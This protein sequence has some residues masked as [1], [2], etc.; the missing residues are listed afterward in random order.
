[1]SII[2]GSFLP[3]PHFAQNPSSL[4]SHKNTGSEE[5]VFFHF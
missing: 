4:F 3:F 5:P 1:M 2:S